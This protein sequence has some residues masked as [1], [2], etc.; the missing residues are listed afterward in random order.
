MGVGDPGLAVDASCTAQHF[1]SEEHLALHA[2]RSYRSERAACRCGNGRTMARMTLQRESLGYD[3]DARPA[4]APPGTAP[5][6]P[7][8]CAADRVA[9]LDR[10]GPERRWLR[11]RAYAWAKRTTDIGLIA[12]CSPLLAA[13]FG[14]CWIAVKLEQPSAPALFFQRRTGRDG[15][16]FRMVKFR[17]MVPD[18]EERKAR[19][20]TMNE[21]HWPDFKIEHDPRITR[22]GRILRR[23]SLDE[24]PQLFNI[25]KG[26]MSLVG[27]RPT[28]FSAETYEEW[29][30]AR[31]AAVPGLTGLW[32]IVGRGEMEFEERVRLDLL[33]IEHQC[34]S[35][36][37]EIL[38]R[39]VGAV[40]TGRGAH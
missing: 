3:L 28:S 33:Y 21:R 32:Q 20:A 7:T 10:F 2:V 4:A 19:L 11:G 14:L 8:S 25:L 40:L 6:R 34:V 5:P 15:K 23:T 24:L 36:D 39:T 16:R 12:A 9:W 38:L 18:A 17:T 35:V 29:Q 26:E 27:P 13:L 31:L 22:V 30:R 37:L 1:E